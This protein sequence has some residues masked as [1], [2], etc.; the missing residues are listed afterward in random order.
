MAV[1]GGAILFC[2]DQAFHLRGQV[3]AMKG[4]AA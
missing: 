4:K 1:A 2:S 3:I